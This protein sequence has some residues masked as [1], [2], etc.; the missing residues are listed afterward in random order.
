MIWVNSWIELVECELVS[1]DD[2]DVIA[3]A[4]VR[5]AGVDVEPLVASID[6]AR[7]LRVCAGVDLP[8]GIDLRA[9]FGGLPFGSLDAV[10]AARAIEIVVKS[11]RKEARKS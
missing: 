8:H 3:V 6:R 9:T 5:V 4:I 2:T 11:L 7:E 1:L 10:A